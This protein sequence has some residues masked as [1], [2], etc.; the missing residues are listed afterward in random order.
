MLMSCLA[1]ALAAIG[2]LLVGA[3]FAAAAEGD[4]FAGSAACSECHA[5]ETAA[6][7][8]SHHGWALREAEEGA[9]LGDFNNASFA[10]K[11]V[12]TRFFRDGSRFM[13]ETDGPD[14]K[15]VTY[16]IRYAVGVTPLQQYL[17]ET[18]NGRLQAL[19]IAWDTVAQKWYHLYP[20]MDVQLI[21]TTEAW[22]Q[23]SV[24]GPNARISSS[25]TKQSSRSPASSMTTFRGFGMT[26]VPRCSVST[27][28]SRSSR[29]ESPS[30]LPTMS[31]PEWTT[32]SATP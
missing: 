14:G 31:E 16:P 22:A 28:M 18:G 21:S 17:V 13:V 9:V 23:F 20:D 1:R 32:I 12:T 2:T 29:P 25:L 10:H 30:F 11:D 27:V 6:W 19:D 15:L 24:A 4:S 7:A 26:V 5:D 8:G 3:S